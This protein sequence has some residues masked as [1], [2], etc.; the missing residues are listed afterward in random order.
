[1]EMLQFYCWD[2]SVLTFSNIFATPR[3]LCITLQIFRNLIDAKNFFTDLFSTPSFPNIYNRLRITH[4]QTCISPVP[5]IL[6]NN[7]HSCCLIPALLE[8]LV[9]VRAFEWAGRG[10][11]LAT[12]GG[13]P[14]SAT[15]QISA[16][17]VCPSKEVNSQVGS[18]TGR[19]EGG[20]K[21]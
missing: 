5:V 14:G 18:E 3:L 11:P 16:N 6:T 13:R 15:Q 8:T 10:F 19:K 12:D 9:C 1:M 20:E 7:K 17:P 4:F 21:G 2:V